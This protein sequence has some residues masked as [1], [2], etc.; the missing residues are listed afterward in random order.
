MKIN[1]QIS[2]IYRKIVT[3][4]SEYERFRIVEKLDPL[5]A[6]ELLVLLMMNNQLR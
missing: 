3:A 5:A 6:K 4:D 1:E 2:K